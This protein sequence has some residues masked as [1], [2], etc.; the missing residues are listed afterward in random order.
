MSSGSIVLVLTGPLHKATGL[1]EVTLPCRENCSLGEV[2]GQFLTQYPAA[3]S[4]CGLPD[5]PDRPLDRLPPGLLVLRDN[6]LLP[7][8]PSTEIGSSQRLTLTPMISGG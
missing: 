3:V 1:Q 6:V 2:L 4:V 5:T 8:I 7:L